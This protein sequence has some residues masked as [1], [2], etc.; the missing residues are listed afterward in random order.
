[1]IY[2]KRMAMKTLST[3]NTEIRGA[4]EGASVAVPVTLPDVEIEELVEEDDGV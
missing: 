3:E 2:A 4:D 1:M